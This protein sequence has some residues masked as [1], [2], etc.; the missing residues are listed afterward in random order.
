MAPVNHSQRG[1]VPGTLGLC[2]IHFES[3]AG[4][5]AAASGSSIE[6]ALPAAG[7]VLAVAKKLTIDETDKVVK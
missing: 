4:Q 5:A 6:A 3:R 2:L 7:G 1:S